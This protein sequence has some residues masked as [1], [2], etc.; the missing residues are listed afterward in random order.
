MLET[1]DLE[2]THLGLRRRI[3][4]WLPPRARG[5]SPGPY[6][7]LYLNDGQNLFE[8]ARAF[9]GRTWRVADTAARLVRQGRIPPLLIVGIDH[10]ESRRSREYL[11]IED[12]RN[13]GAR[14]PLGRRYAE[15]VTGE[16]MPL[17][18]RTYPVAWGASNS[19]FGG[20]SYGAVAALYTA[21]LKPGV[22]GRLLLES[23]SLYVGGQYLLRRAR[24]A[25]RWPSRIYLGVGTVETERAEVNDEAVANV[26]RLEALLLR[27]RFGARRLLTVV[28]EGAAHSEDA[29]AGRL[30][31]ALEFLYGQR[32]AI[33]P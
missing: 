28:E 18:R 31:R 4:V 2:S 9:A 6:P 32:R 19:G 10:G 14:K 3:T 29:W 8:P 16:V 20:S 23:P 30:P 17:I 13:P 22:F 5:D 21:M 33:G 1:H 24:T 25:Q 12:D 7:V 15:F 27:R 26:R 11:P